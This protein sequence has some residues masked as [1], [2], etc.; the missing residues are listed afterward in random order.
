[1]IDTFFF[2]GA[3]ALEEP[4]KVIPPFLEVLNLFCEVSGLCL[5]DQIDKLLLCNW[6][7]GHFL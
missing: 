2:V 6:K 7:M 4:G 3:Q 1:M 5:F